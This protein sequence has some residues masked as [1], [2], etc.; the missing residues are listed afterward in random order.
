MNLDY[1]SNFI[2]NLKYMPYQG[3]TDHS[4]VLTNFTAR[5]INLT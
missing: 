2:Y 4:L 5:V 1:C 3:Y